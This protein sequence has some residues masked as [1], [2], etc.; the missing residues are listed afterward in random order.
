M[1]ARGSCAPSS[2]PRPTTCTSGTPTSGRR[3]SCSG[4]LLLVDR[5]FVACP[6]PNRDDIA[7][8]AIEE[9]IRTGDPRSV[10]QV[11]YRYSFTPLKAGELEADEQDCVEIQH[12]GLGCALLK[13][14]LLQRMVDTFRELDELQMPLEILQGAL[15]PTQ[16][17]R[18]S[19]PKLEQLTAALAREVGLWRRGHLGLVFDD[20]WKKQVHSTVALFQ[21]MARRPAAGMANVLLGE[22]TAFCQRVRDLG[23]QVWMYLGPGSPVDHIG[24]HVYRGH[25]ETLGLARVSP[26]EYAAARA[27]AAPT[28][29]VEKGEAMAPPTEPS[30]P[31]ELAS[32]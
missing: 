7:F 3:R 26:E 13:R 30:P 10:E 20:K 23:G 4:Q 16:L 21:L 9:K 29:A 24:D 31:P 14:E 11:A 28:S 6:Y 8:D 22:D 2:R 1:S 15:D 27:A 5:D 17:G 19:R 12:I 32:P 25:I 18:L